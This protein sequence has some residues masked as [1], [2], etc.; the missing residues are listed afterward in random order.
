MNDEEFRVLKAISE[1]TKTINFGKT[2]HTTLLRLEVAQL[3]KPHLGNG[4]VITEKGTQ[5][6]TAKTKE[7]K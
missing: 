4:H 5:F 1:G 6:L 7:P 2:L 3:V